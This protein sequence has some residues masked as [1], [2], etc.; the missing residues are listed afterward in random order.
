MT[1]KQFW[2]K[3]DQISEAKKTTGEKAE[4]LASLLSIRL[5]L[6]IQIPVKFP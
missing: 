1:D 4:A 5:C 6:Q 3:A 2:M